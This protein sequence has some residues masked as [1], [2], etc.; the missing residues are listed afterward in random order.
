M[1][2]QR[3]QVF[4]E[5]LSAVD[6]F[7][8]WK[9]WA[10][11]VRVSVNIKQTEKATGYGSIICALWWI[12]HSSWI[13]LYRRGQ[14]FNFTACPHWICTRASS[15]IRSGFSTLC[16]VYSEL[17]LVK[18]FDLCSVCTWDTNKGA[19]KRVWPV[20][21]QSRNYLSWAGVSPARDRQMCNLKFLV[22]VC[23]D[24]GGR[25]YGCIQMDCY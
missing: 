6:E 1:Q 23:V 16:S 14:P 4:R 12:L 18:G 24:R 8:A 25:S 5:V 15:S 2:L 20:K 17:P 3:L 19:C 11:L 21:K 7:I 9:I 10:S 13:F 22:E